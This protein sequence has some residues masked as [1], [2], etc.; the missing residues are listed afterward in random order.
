MDR[1]PLSIFLQNKNARSFRII[2][3]VF[4]DDSVLNS[5]YNILNENMVFRKFIVSMI[6]NPDF[7]V[8]NQLQDSLPCVT[9]E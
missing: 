7:P 2:R 3:I 8:C 9:H 6:G 1:F 4:D 5:F